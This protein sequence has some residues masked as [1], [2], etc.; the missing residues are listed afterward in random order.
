[1]EKSSLRRHAAV[2]E[3]R[4]SVEMIS[5]WT[6]YA[7]WVSQFG[8]AGAPYLLP[9]GILLISLSVLGYQHGEEPLL[10]IAA[11]PLRNWSLFIVS[12]WLS[13]FFTSLGA[14]VVPNLLMLLFG[15]VIRSQKDYYRY[16]QNYFA[17]ILASLTAVFL[18]TP[19]VV[20]ATWTKPEEHKEWQDTVYKL[21]QI[22][23]VMAVSLGLEKAFLQ[24]VAVNFHQTTYQDRIKR[25][26]YEIQVLDML[27]KAVKKRGV[28]EPLSSSATELAEA[29][30]ANEKKSSFQLTRIKSAL[31]NATT[32]LGSIAS[33]ILEVPAQQDTKTPSKHMMDSVHNLLGNIQGA[34]LLAK[35]LYNGIC[36]EG[37]K[38]IIVQD[39]ATLGAFRGK[40]EVQSAFDILDQDGNG[41]LSRSEIRTAVLRIFRE[42]KMIADSLRD[43]DHAVSKLD[44]I[45][46]VFVYFFV[47]LV[48][49]S[50]FDVDV[51]TFLATAGSV[52]LGLSFMVG[53]TAQAIFESCIFIFVHHPYDVGDH[54]EIEGEGFTV[55]EM[56]LLHTVFEDGTGK[57][58]M[59]PNN[60]LFQKF[61]GNIRR[62]GDMSE[63]VQIETDART[64]YVRIVALE[65]KLLDFLH[66]EKRDFHES[67]NLVVKELWQNQRI[68]LE[69]EIPHRGNAQ[70]GL[71]WN[72]RRNKFMFALKKALEESGIVYHGPM[73]RILKQPQ[74][75]LP[76]ALVSV[77]PTSDALEAEMEG[78]D[79]V[80]YSSL[81]KGG[82]SN[83]ISDSDFARNTVQVKKPFG[84]K[85]EEVVV[86]DK[87]KERVVS[88]GKSGTLDAALFV[89]KLMSARNR[90]KER[91]AAEAAA[92]LAKGDE[93]DEE[94]ED[95]DE[96]DDDGD[97][98]NE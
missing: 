77:G 93:D 94:D 10:V 75:V 62:S 28:G 57:M 12:V 47:L 43:L 24:M 9:L 14:H 30:G 96:E 11:V 61:I 8:V 39:F 59:A 76:S 83:S 58:V 51:G 36:P 84:L 95:H 4:Q 72:Q 25:S 80:I 44:N 64:E 90:T 63:T 92:L 68:I 37:K 35:K 48:G 46:K 7:R 33:E 18:W 81:P 17:F 56:A 15:E 78:M 52:I 22:T 82:N 98:E 86:F 65:R 66:K 73:Q 41:D 53:S 23:A 55:R 89:N 87:E 21:L 60:Q 69:L 74:T 29:L 91:E 19:M 45:L 88:L 49:I 71:K 13:F 54:V 16:M 6:R 40:E 20:D 2:K 79:A 38:E 31:S 26:K 34:R 97:D 27:Y 85:K 42:R 1:M 3:T 32:T 70:D 50:F 67:C 5:S